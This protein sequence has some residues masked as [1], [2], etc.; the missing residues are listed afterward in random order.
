MNGSLAYHFLFNI[1]SVIAIRERYLI[2]TYKN[3]SKIHF[4]INLVN[5]EYLCHPLIA[6]L[7]WMLPSNMW[8]KN[9]IIFFALYQMS[10]FCL[11]LFR[12]RWWGFFPKNLI[13]SDKTLSPTLM[14][15]L[16]MHSEKCLLLFAYD[17]ML[18]EKTS[19]CTHYY[20]MI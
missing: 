13:T 18:L 9:K 20:Y 15:Y 5:I 2:K 11:R 1:K 6:I 7:V 10:Q 8:P 12:P 16:I 19:K 3:H 4:C 17:K 14:L